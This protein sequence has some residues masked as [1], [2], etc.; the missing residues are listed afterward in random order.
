MIGDKGRILQ[1]GG[2]PPALHHHMSITS[3]FAAAIWRCSPLWILLAGHIFVLLFLRDLGEGVHQIDDP[4][5]MAMA[6]L[7]GQ[8]HQ[9][10]AHW[11]APPLLALIAFLQVQLIRGKE[12]DWGVDLFG[13]LLTLRCLVIFLML[14]LLLLSHL[15]AGGM[16]LL[17]LILF[18]PVITIDFGWIYWRLDSAARRRG[19]SHIRF[20]AEMGELDA[21]DYYHV[22]AM[23][24]L[25]FEPSGAKPT[26]RIMKTLFVIHGVMM[27]DLVALTL[28]R[29]IGLAAGG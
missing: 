22:S 12:V 18:I 24:L 9:L 20:D 4:H 26:S 15:K 27:L 17:Q 3:P 11:V 6:H 2:T 10:V 5:A 19:S 7:L 23:T 28:S 16:L 21:F 14:N 13:V 8:L 29:A 1:Q 25:Q